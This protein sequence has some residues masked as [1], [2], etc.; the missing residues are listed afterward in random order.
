ML[1]EPV[2]L[3]TPRRIPSP[4]PSMRALRLSIL[5]LVLAFAAAGQA[6]SQAAQRIA[7]VGWLAGCLEMRSG[8]RV[9][10][11]QR[12]AER[13]GTMLGMGRTVNA[14]GLGDYELTLIKEEA[15]RLL[16]EAHPKGQPPATFA[17]RVA[18][19]DSVVFEAPEHDFPQ[20]VGYRRVGADSVLAW[21]EG[22]MNGKT[23]R[24]EFP[25]ARI[26]CP[27]SR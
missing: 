2:Q 8:A 4:R 21:V 13:A 17:A 26:A 15:G 9:V 7:T 27:T 25:Y 10:E 3:A 12:M 16:F 14:R 5:Q 19:T 18:T 23:R 11:E 1:P 6:E 22:S 24:V 20:R